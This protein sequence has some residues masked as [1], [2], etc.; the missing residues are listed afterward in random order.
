MNYYYLCKQGS[1]VNSYMPYL[2]CLNVL[3]ILPSSYMNSLLQKNIS[4]IKFQGLHCGPSVSCMGYMYNLRGIVPQ[5][6]TCNKM[7]LYYIT[8]A[9]EKGKHSKSDVYIQE[10]ILTVENHPKYH[11]EHT[12]APGVDPGFFSGGEVH[13]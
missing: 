12:L 7:F 10:K 5:I 13:H 2:P 4:F 6:W 11:S 9:L 1:T 3:L 8:L